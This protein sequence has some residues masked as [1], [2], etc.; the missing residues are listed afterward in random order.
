MAD[1]LAIDIERKARAQG[2]HAQHI[3]S[4]RVMDASIH[5]FRQ[6]NQRIRGTL[7][8]IP[9][10]GALRDG[11][12]VEIIPRAAERRPKAEVA[13][14]SRLARRGKRLDFDT[15]IAEAPLFWLVDCRLVVW[16]GDLY[17]IV[18]RLMVANEIIV[19]LLLCGPAG[20]WICEA[21]VVER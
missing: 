3:F 18:F 19:K 17:V 9:P 20:S 1:K 7:E 10:L 14:L 5:A 16:A 4:I 12:G 6:D 8:H 15:G 2:I 13:C 21:V 11:K